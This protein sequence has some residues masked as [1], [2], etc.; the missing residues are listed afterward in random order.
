MFDLT[1]K[2]GVFGGSSSSVLSFSESNPVTEFGVHVSWAEVVLARKQEQYI[3]IGIAAGRK[4][5]VRPQNLGLLGDS[6]LRNIL[7]V[8][9]LLIVRFLVWIQGRGPY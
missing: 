2:H 1:L 7:L 8:T 5:L 3:L 4:W 6:N 9:V